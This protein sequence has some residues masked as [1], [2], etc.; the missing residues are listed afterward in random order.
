MDKYL[1]LVSMVKCATCEL[2][3]QSLPMRLGT[4]GLLVK[5]VPVPGSTEYGQM[6][7]M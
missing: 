4:L 2:L 3:A 7:H 6:C 5:K 1:V